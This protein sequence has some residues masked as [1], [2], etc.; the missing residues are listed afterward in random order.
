MFL[1]LFCF[2][3]KQENHMDNENDGL[4]GLDRWMS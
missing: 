1:V 3:F 2:L 4:G